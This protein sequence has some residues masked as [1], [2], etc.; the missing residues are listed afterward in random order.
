MN[1]II[2]CELKKILQRCPAVERAIL[3]GSRARGDFNEKSDYDVA[4]Y[5][6]LDSADK[7]NLRAICA[8]DLPTLHKIDLVFIDGKIDKEF[9]K[10]IKNE[11]I[12][13]YDK[14]GK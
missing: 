7:T 5:G 9:L 13:F 2:L 11:G 14:A 12:L 3:F 4:V 8:E 1:D 6:D 10:N